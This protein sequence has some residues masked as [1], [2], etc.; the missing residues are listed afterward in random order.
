MNILTKTFS[1]RKKPVKQRRH[2]KAALILLMQNQ[3]II[4]RIKA[5]ATSFL[6]KN[7]YG[8]LSYKNATNPGHVGLVGT[9]SEERDPRNRVQGTEA[10]LFDII[11]ESLC[12]FILNSG[13][14]RCCVGKYISLNILIYLVAH[15]SFMYYYN[16]SFVSL[17]FRG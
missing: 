14:V 1:P 8:T 15:L 4:R 3:Q 13:T 12:N 5:C 9:G 7:L 6:E 16:L 2:C 17:G 10:D 11:I